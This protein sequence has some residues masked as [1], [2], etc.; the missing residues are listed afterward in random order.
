MA[1][2][3]DSVLFVPAGPSFRVE[4]EIK[5]VVV[6]VAKTCHYLFDHLEPEQMPVGEAP[7]L[8][9]PPLPQEIPRNVSVTKLPQPN[10]NKTFGRP[11][12]DNPRWRFARLGR[13]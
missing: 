13:V 7:K 10:S 1:R 6:A 9:R 8:I 5:N 12:H 11:R 4:K 2:N 3:E